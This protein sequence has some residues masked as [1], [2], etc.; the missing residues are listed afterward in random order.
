MSHP[1]PPIKH[2]NATQPHTNPLSSLVF[3]LKAVPTLQITFC[4]S[5]KN[6]SR[7]IQEAVGVVQTSANLIED[8]D[9]PLEISYQMHD[10]L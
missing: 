8:E 9:L 6:Y 4:W 5:Q 1:P 2:E 7:T 3:C 10:S